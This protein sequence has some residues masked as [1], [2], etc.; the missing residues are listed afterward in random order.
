MTDAPQTAS[1]LRPPLASVDAARAGLRLRRSRTGPFLTACRVAASILVALA[2]TPSIATAQTPEAFGDALIRFTALLGGGYGDEGP[3]ARAALTALTRTLA[4]WDSRIRDREQQVALLAGPP[5]AQSNARVELARAFAARGRTADALRELATAARLDD[6]RAD[7]FL[8]AGIVHAAA[9]RRTDAAMAFRHAWQRHPQDPAVAY[10]ALSHADAEWSAD[11]RAQAGAV[12]A[13]AYR[14]AAQGRRAGGQPFVA[15][16]LVDPSRVATPVVLPAAYAEGFALLRRGEYDAALAS[17][18]STLERDPLLTDPVSGSPRLAEGAEALREGRLPVAR[19]RFEGLVAQA[20][21]SSEAHRLLGIVHLAALLPEKSLVELTEAVRLQPE[22][23]RSNVTLARV[24]IQTN[25]LQE[26]EARLRLTLTLVPASAFARLWLGTLFVT[27]NRNLDAAQVFE[28]LAEAPV[29]AGLAQ[30]YGNIARFREGAADFEAVVAA[31]RRRVLLTPNDPDA[32]T[33]MARGYLDLDRQDDAFAE[34][35]AALLIDP[36]N[37]LAYMG[38]GQLHLNA[39]R[40]EDAAVA[41]RRLVTLQPAFPEGRYA[42]ANALLRAGKTD[43]GDRELVEFQRL[44]VQAADAKR[45]SMA[46]DVLKEEAALRASE[47]EF[48]RAA[49]LWRQVIEQEPRGVANHA[50]LGAAL[51]GSGDTAAAVQA[52]ERAASLGGG[53]DVY[54]QLATLYAS[55]GREQDSAR[56]RARY[57]QALLTPPLDGARR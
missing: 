41:L 52:Y 54:R 49:A 16:P 12:L 25:A 27:M 11:E 10:W 40:Y 13:A 43:E 30:V 7:A 36:D 19:E 4:E 24:L 20:P 32:H 23:E 1:P 29:I 47:H 57:E 35:A 9:G 8:L 5:A 37:P 46:L 48:E 42:L 56:A 44:Q 22:D 39:G 21:A 45:R 17:F 55:L 3:Q 6:T 15:F 53:A 33:D 26:A 34:Y 14:S 2:A 31:E 51:A 38:I 50:G 28:G 18:H